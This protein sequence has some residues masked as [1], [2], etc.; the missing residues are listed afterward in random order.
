MSRRRV[1][2]WL[3]AGPSF[4]DKSNVDAIAPLVA[5]GTR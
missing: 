1:L 3:V 4:V 2:P 5:Q